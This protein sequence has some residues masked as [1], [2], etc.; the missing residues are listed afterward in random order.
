ML[1]AKD[2]MTKEV[3]RVKK[4]TPIYEAVELLA[5]N[6]V[7]GIPVVKDDMTLVGILTEKDVLRLF[8]ADEDEKNKTVNYF[9]TQPAVHF[10]EDESLP[11]VCN[12]LMDNPFRRVPVTSSGKLVGI[13]SRPDFIKYILQLRHE[14]IGIA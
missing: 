5:K 6:E 11:D 2:I 10:D 1:E 9:M 12:C 4:D 3:I 14:S 8:Y 7:T 13:I